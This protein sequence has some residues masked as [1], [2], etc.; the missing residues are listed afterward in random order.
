MTALSEF[1]GAEQIFS[2]LRRLQFRRWL[3]RLMT[4]LS[5]A[6]AVLAGGT[7]PAHAEAEDAD[8]CEAG[9]GVMAG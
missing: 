5:A 8:M 2:E 3:V 9:K 7:Y 6:A 1:D 4:G